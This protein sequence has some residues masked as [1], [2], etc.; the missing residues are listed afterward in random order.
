M[1]EESKEDNIS[2]VEKE[3]AKNSFD[4]K[5]EV[6]SW[7]QTI[8]LAFVFAFLIT[9]F[10]IVNA[11]VP[12]GSMKTTINEGDRLVANRLSYL[13]SEPQRGDIVVFKFPDNESVLYIKRVI[14]TPGDVVKIE[15]G[16]V[17]I[18]DELYDDT[19]F[20]RGS[21]YPHNGVTEYVVPEGSYFML[22]DNRENSADS[23]YWVNT[24]VK[25]DKILGK[26]VFRYWEGI[27]KISFSIFA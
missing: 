18:N 9:N 14:G 26:A 16:R 12:T 19:E 23:R 6:I 10:L 24:F 3:T 22:G 4:L 8:V 15:D 25:K 2:E 17:Y 21:T 11:T 27:G 5:G 20:A 1:S 7:I 13:F